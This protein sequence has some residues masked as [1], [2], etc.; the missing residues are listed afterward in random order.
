MVGVGRSG[1]DTPALSLTRRE[2][3]REYIELTR[4][5]YSTEVD[6]VDPVFF[7]VVP[8]SFMARESQGRSLSRR[9]W[10]GTI[11]GEEQDLPVVAPNDPWSF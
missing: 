11:W 8:D 3:R 9:N 6:G 10:D 2:N 1:C 5:I 4:V 7:A